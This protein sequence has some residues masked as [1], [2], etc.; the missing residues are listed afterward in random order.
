ME[1]ANRKAILHQ[2]QFIGHLREI[3]REWRET[4]SWLAS[5]DAVPEHLRCDVGLG[6][7]SRFFDQ[8]PHGRSFDHTLQRTLNERFW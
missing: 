7:C 4:R 8:K 3:A 6:G 2:P 1:T 5:I